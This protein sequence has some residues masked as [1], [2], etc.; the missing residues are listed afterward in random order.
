MSDNFYGRILFKKLQPFI[1]NVLSKKRTYF[2]TGFRF[3]LYKGEVA[4][5]GLQDEIYPGKQGLHLMKDFQRD[6][7]ILVAAE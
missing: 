1:N 3:S 4:G 5:T 7:G 2:L 6:K